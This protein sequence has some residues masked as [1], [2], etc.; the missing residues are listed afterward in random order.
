MSLAHQVQLVSYAEG[1][2]T[3]ENFS[4]QKIVLRDLEP[5]ECLVEN[6]YI[7]IDPAM[8]RRCRTQTSNLAQLPLGG[9]IPSYAIGRVLLSRRP[10]FAEGDYL[11]HYAGWESHSIVLKPDP[12]IGPF[13]LQKA[14]PEVAALPNYIGALGSKGFTAHVGMTIVGKVKAGDRVLISGAAGGV[15]SFSGQIAKRAGA[16]VVG[17]AG[18]P[19]KCRFV[20]DELGFDDCVDYRAADVGAEIDRALPGGIDFYLDNVGGDL[21]DIVMNRMNPNGRFI[22]SGMVAEYQTDSVVRGPNL[23]ITVTRNFKVEGFQNFR[24]QE[25][26]PA[27]R[28]AMAATLR[29]GEIVAKYDI[30]EG[31]E[32]APAALVGLMAGANFGTKLMRISRD[33]TLPA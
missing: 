15:G 25:H 2:V 5:G 1:P 22:I 30:G 12:A 32:N 8:T 33:P 4:L 19:A 26:Y 23:F 3:A 28:D 6:I 13:R 29:S 24:F 7:T 31:L 20:I 11:A 18:G 17:L 14:L 10:E 21:Q 16:C 9:V 27:F